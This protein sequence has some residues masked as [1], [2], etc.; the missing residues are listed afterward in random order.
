[1]SS[2][3]RQKIDRWLKDQTFE[4]KSVLDVGGGAKES[5]NLVKDFDR[6]LVLDID[7]STKP[8][9]IHDLNEFKHQDQIFTA[10]REKQF[11]LIFCLHVFE[12]I[13]NPYTAMANLYSWLKPE[14]TLVVN[15][16][17]IYPI[18]KP[19]GIDYLRYTH[20]FVNH[21]FTKSF[22][23]SEVE[24]TIIE[25]D[26]SLLKAYYAQDKTHMRNDEN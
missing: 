7:E 20:E 23:F 19:E 11:D 18:H 3:Y 6:Y 8:D 12:Y 4:G 17:F 22:T 24:H 13:H 14:G 1:M 21:Y 2:I 16:P 10:E 25:T 15:F 5:K 26:S 9:I